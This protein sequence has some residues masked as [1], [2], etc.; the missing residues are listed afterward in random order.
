M[1]ILAIIYSVLLAYHL[2]CCYLL[3]GIW[4]RN[5]AESSFTILHHLLKVSAD[6]FSQNLYISTN[7]PRGGD[8]AFF[9]FLGKGLGPERNFR[10]K[11]AR[12]RIRFNPK[13]LQ[14]IIP[15]KIIFT[16]L[17]LALTK[18]LVLV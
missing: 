18:H 12:S 15:K 2:M 14:M 13:P 9:R 6:L 17:F 1:Y 8:Q 4:S 5:D 16:I 11:P 10:E 7:N 3:W